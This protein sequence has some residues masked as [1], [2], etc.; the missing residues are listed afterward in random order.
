[1]GPLTDLYPCTK[2][3]KVLFYPRTRVMR[4]MPYVEKTKQKS[5]NEGEKV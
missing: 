5:G 3:G 2:K 1:M 4:G